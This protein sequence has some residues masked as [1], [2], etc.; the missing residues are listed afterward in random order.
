[1]KIKK[2]HN[3]QLIISWQIN[4][5]WNFTIFSFTFTKWFILKNLKILITHLCHHWH[6]HFIAKK[7]INKIWKKHILLQS[8][9][10]FEKNKKIHFIKINNTCVHIESLLN[11]SV[12]L[13]LKNSICQNIKILSW[14]FLL[15]ILNLFL[16]KQN[17]YLKNCEIHY[18]F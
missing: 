13:W 6:K 9:H 7:H 17:W 14:L 1:M 15:N 8:N 4:A 11:H 12:F 2:K 5:F 16:I 3:K 18:F 10:W